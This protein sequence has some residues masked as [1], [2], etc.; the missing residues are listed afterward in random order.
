ML[1]AGVSALNK[2][3]IHSLLSEA[4]VSVLLLCWNIGITIFN[5]RSGYVDHVNG[6]G[7]IWPAIPAII[8][9]WQ[10]KK[11]GH[12]GEA[13]ASMDQ[14]RVKEA[15][16]LCKQLFQS[17]LKQSPDI[18]QAS[19]RRCRLRLMNG[20]VFCAQRN[21]AQAFH[22]SREN[23]GQCIRDIGRKRLRVVV[24][25]PLGKITYGFDKKNSDKI[26]G[27]LTVSSVQPA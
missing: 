16:A 20:S 12:L 3:T 1:G 22:M 10:Y 27:W 18:V 8:F 7:L 5:I 2:P 11:L 14:A 24:R 6:H 13:I 21:L 26:K 4:V 15:S 23:F 9:F 17:R 25:H 19:S